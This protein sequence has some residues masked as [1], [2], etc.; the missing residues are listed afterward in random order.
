MGGCTKEKF[1]EMAQEAAEEYLNGDDKD[2][3]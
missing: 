2:D 1:M 3:A